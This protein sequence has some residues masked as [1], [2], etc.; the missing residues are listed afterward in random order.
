MGIYMNNSFY[1]AIKAYFRLNLKMLLNDKLSFLWSVIFPIGFILSGNYQVVKPIQL[2]GYY[3]YIIFYA[4]VV[5]LVVDCIYSRNSGNLKVYFSIKDTRLE[6]FLANLLNQMLFSFLS[7]TAI[8]VVAAIYYKID[9]LETMKYGIVLII[10]CIP[11][12]FLFFAMTLIKNISYK[13][14]STILT[15]ITAVFAMMMPHIFSVSINYINPMI[16]MTLIIWIDSLK[17]VLIYTIAAVICV[18]IGLVSISKYNA[19]SNE[20]R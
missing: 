1:N 11:V 7:I 6:F 13:T 18:T 2:G 12:A 19:M 14:L 5:Q 17:G 3:A 10:T 8:N 16:Y 15:I 4:Y 20:V 9:F